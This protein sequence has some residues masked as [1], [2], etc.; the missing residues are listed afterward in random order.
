MKKLITV[1]LTLIL[2]LPVIANATSINIQFIDHQM[3]NKASEIDTLITYNFGNGNNFIPCSEAPFPCSPPFD[4]NTPPPL[5][6][7]Y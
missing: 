7:C 5:F 3:P 4:M 2:V 6:P 1:I